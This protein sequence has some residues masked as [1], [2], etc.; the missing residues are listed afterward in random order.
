MSIGAQIAPREGRGVERE[1]LSG[2]SPGWTPGQMMA[3][4]LTE[5]RNFVAG[6]FPNVT[7]TGDWMDIAHYSQII[8]PTTTDLGCGVATGSGRQ[9]LV[10]RYS[11]GGN[12][13]GKPVGQRLSEPQGG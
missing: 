7:R 8:W 10:C 2:G 1:N 6:I 12:K 4:W 9:W 13:D 11:P 5:K 3:V